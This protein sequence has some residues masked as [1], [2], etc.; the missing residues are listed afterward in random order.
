M[1]NIQYYLDDLLE[2][3]ELNTK[4]T[5]YDRKIR[6]YQRSTPMEILES[7]FKRY[8]IRPNFISWYDNVQNASFE[9]YHGEWWCEADMPWYCT[10][11]YDSAP[12]YIFTRSPRE[13]NKMTTLVRICT[14]VV[15]FLIFLALLSVCAFFKLNSYVGR[16]LG[17]RFG[18]EEILLCPFRLNLIQYMLHLT[19][20]IFP[21]S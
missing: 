14:P 8:K 11:P 18:H 13:L 9:I 17:L 19:S 20:V 12:W 10:P 16:K 15:W 6:R 5:N 2:D 21:E 7:F 1:V 4:L 3:G